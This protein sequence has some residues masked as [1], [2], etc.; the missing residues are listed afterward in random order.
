MSRVERRRAQRN[1]GKKAVYQFTEEQLNQIIEEQVREK[2]EQAKKDT[3]ETAVN[4]AMTLLLVLPME[5]L[6]DYYWPK[7]YAKRIPEF[8]DRV[9]EYYYKWQIGELDMDK[10][11]EDLWVYGG[12]RLE[13]TSGDYYVNREK[14][15]LAE[16]EVE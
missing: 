2:I 9:L 4:L 15:R 11:K 14:E 1:G 10:M 12:V 3:T 5:V 13:E 16:S 6:M 7:S 8:T